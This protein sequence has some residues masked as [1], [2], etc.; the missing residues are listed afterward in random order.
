MQIVRFRS[1]IGVHNFRPTGKSTFEQSTMRS[2][3]QPRITV[4]VL[5]R[6]RTFPLVQVDRRFDA[7]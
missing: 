3:E 5:W 2:L 6:R 4:N 1:I 7:R